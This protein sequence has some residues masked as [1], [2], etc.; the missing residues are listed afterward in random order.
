MAA[1]FGSTRY[2]RLDY[3]NN[4]LPSINAPSTP[5]A[6]EKWFTESGS[7]LQSG[8]RLVLYVTAHGGKGPTKKDE[9]HHN[10]K[11]YTWNWQSLYAEKLSELI[12]GLPQGVSVVTVMVQ[13]Y[14]GGFSNLIFDGNNAKNADTD[15]DICGFFA[16]VHSR[17]SAGCT[18]DINEED[19][20]EYSSHFWAALRGQSRTG[21]DIPSA[22]YD[23]DGHISFAEA[24]AYTLLTSKNIDVPVKTSDAFLR[25]H[26]QLGD[27]ENSTLIS[28]DAPYFQLLTHAEPSELAVLD[29]L[30][31][32]LDL[33][34][35]TRATLARDRSK[36][37]QDQRKKLADE[38]KDKKRT[39]DSLKR[40]I[41]NDIRY[42]WPDLSNILSPGAVK[43][44]T[45]HSDEFVAAVKSH[46]KY[47]EWDQVAKRRN[48]I[49]SQRFDL[50]KTWARHQRFI[51]TLENI[52]LAQNLPEVAGPPV[53]ERFQKLVAAERRNLQTLPQ[54]QPIAADTL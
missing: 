33:T 52:A 47:K 40:T 29:S 46:P 38:D 49:Q 45:D 34:G 30:S 21:K 32:Q 1:L 13:C 23:G 7:K 54:G 41:S 37:I 44:L 2:L 16:A 28:A 42:R 4:E 36:E 6:V 22:D 51:R 50:D 20:D 12:A 8:D 3:R 53:I 17:Q 35:N 48:A 19:Y 18:P 5:A 43:I 11:I 9:N 25:K 14:S 27:G 26:S 10:T 24:H 31:N 39:F 15:R